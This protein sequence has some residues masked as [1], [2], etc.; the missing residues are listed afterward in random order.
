[1]ITIL[2]EIPPK[3]NKGTWCGVDI[4]LFNADVEK[5]HLPITGEFASLQI[6]FTNGDVYV[7][8][9]VK[10]VPKALKA[11]DNCM[12]VFMKGQF[13][14]AHLRR[15]AKVPDRELMWDVMYIEKI[16]WGG[17]FEAFSLADLVRRNLDIHMDKSVREQFHSATELTEEMIQYAALDA[18]L[19]LKVAEKQQKQQ[20]MTK[21]VYENIWQDIDLPATYALLDSMPFRIDR[22][23]WIALAEKNRARQEEINATLPFNP[24]SWQQVKAALIEAGFEGLP[25]TGDDVLEEYIAKFPDTEAVAIARKIQDSRMY[26]KRASTYGLA[27]L[28]KHLIEIEGGWGM[29]PD[30]FTIGAETGRVSCSGLH[31]IPIR[32]TK[33]FRE[34]FIARDGNKLVIADYSSQEPRIAAFLSQDRE[35]IAVMNSGKDIYTEACRHLYQSEEETIAARKNNKDIVLGTTYGLTPYG[36]SRKW[37]ISQ[38]RAE[39]FIDGFFERFPKLKK[40]LDGLAK[41]TTSVKTVA[42][43]T[44]WLNKYSYQC[45][46]N[47]LNSPHQGT[48][49]DMIKRVLAV[50]KK[51]WKPAWGRYAL[52]ECVHDEIGF[53][54]P[55]E[56]AQEV[57]DWTRN[58]MISVAEKMCPGVK[59]EVGITICDKWSEAK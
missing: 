30:Y 43:R 24:G 46:N 4:E 57:A 53:D 15:W 11:I 8:T 37:G 10:D 23:A 50:T 25:S 27:F 22:D 18:Y 7:I 5:L 29:K 17:F 14:I 35:Y 39:D 6:A 3:Q 34:C 1:M 28:E 40:Y 19:T 54:V 47:A 55:E 52:V 42:G 56:I 26:G 33:E 16:L 36:L 58:T 13:D 21:A 45:R 49:A 20:G 32:E 38:S 59:F 44:I 2:K 48:A 51:N 9:N 41:Q 31:Q 12:W